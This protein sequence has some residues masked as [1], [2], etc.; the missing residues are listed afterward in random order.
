MIK[1][2]CQRSKLT[3]NETEFAV[4][5]SVELPE[6]YTIP[7][8]ID[9]VNQNGYGSCVSCSL[10]DLIRAKY[11]LTGK[12]WTEHFNKWYKE[13][14]DK[15]IDG[16]APLEAF[17]SAKKLGAIDNFAKIGSFLLLKTSLLLN[18]PAMIALPCYDTYA[19]KFWIQNGSM[20]GGHAL[21]V[22]GYTKNGFILKNSWGKQYGDN[23]YAILPYAE[24]SNAFECWTLV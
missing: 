6:T 15:S 12:T 3:G 22:T 21:S 19:T 11:G 24:F 23:G 18:G 8:K 7:I 4:S 13:R 14:K 2:G 20:L 1:L 9:I 10:T 5:Y 17:E 16:M